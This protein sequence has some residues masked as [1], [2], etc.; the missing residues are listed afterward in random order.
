[1][2]AGLVCFVDIFDFIEVGSSVLNVVVD[3]VSS[4]LT[5]VVD[6]GTSVVTVAADVGTSPLT[7]EVVVEL[8]SRRA[9]TFHL[10]ISFGA[11]F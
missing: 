5:V 7:L 11:H 9:V 1:M 4:V 2:I 6:T 3:A 8:A 10:A